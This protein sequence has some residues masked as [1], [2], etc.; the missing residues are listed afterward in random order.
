MANGN[1]QHHSRKALLF[2]VCFLLLAICLLGPTT[3]TF[4]EGWDLRAKLGL[5][6]DLISHDYYL[7]TIDTLGLTPDSLLELNSYNDLIDEQGGWMRVELER[8]GPLELTFGGRLYLTNEKIRS[9][10]DVDARWQS[11]RFLSST[12]LKSYNDS[13]DFS[14]YRRQLRNSSRL[15]LVLWSDPR[16]YLEASQEVEYTDYSEAEPTITGYSQSE[17]RLRFRRQFSD[18]SELDLAL[19]LDL[20]NNLDSAELDFKRLVGDFGFTHIAREGYYS[21]ELYFERRDYALPDSEDDYFYLSPEI[22]FDRVLTGSLNI[23]PE[24]RLHYYNYDQEDYATFSHLRFEG[25]LLLKYHYRLLSSF[26]FGVGTEYFAA[27]DGNYADQDYGAWQ[28]LAGY[29]TYSSS[30]LTLTADAAVGRRNYGISED[31]YYTD[32]DFIQ[33][34]LL[35]DLALTKQLR[36]S[37]IAGT[38]LEYHADQ[39]DNVFLHLLSTTLTYKIR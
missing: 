14:L 20:R 38:D 37:L 21:G 17:S 5:N 33:L 4:A 29:E 11:L 25:E 6:Y 7:R 35:V 13:E 22:Q 16:N 36:L 34:D 23:A 27:G 26:N 24:V 1:P 15:G 8:Q 19:R 39:E 32:Y 12:E 10:F 9:V 18:F 28:L 3:A 2:R 31:E 30:W